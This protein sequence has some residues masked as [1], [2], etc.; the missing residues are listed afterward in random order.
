MVLSMG[1]YAIAVRYLEQNFDLL[2]NQE[3]RSMKAIGFGIPASLGASF[4][5]RVLTR[6]Q[7]TASTTGESVMFLSSRQT[8]KQAGVHDRAAGLREKGGVD[9]SSPPM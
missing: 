8:M 7:E 6:H 3:G 1:D 9:R 5:N 2:Q 4:G